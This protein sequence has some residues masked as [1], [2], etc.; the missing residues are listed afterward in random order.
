MMSRSPSLSDLGS[1]LMTKQGRTR[2]V[3]IVLAAIG[4][5]A[6]AGCGSSNDD[7]YYCDSAGCYQCDAYGC[8]SVAAPTHQACTG[9]ASCP[10]GS[11]CTASGCTTT[12]SDG[13]PCAKGEVCKAGL[14]AAPAVD[15]GVKKDCTT[16]SDCGDGKACVAGSCEACG[17]VAGP[18]PC[19]AAKAATDCAAGQACIAGSCTSASNTCKF[20]SECDSGKVCAGGQ[21]L[22]S[23]EATPCATGFTCDKAVCKPTA[24]GGSGCATDQQCGGDTPQCVAGACVKAC[25]GDPECG[26]GKFCDQGACVI[27]TRPHPNCTD[28]SQCAGSGA[29]R[30]CL[31]G[32]CKYTCTVSQGDAYCRTIDNRIGY[33][34]KDLVCRSAAEANA[35]CLQSSECSD[36]KV[37]IDNSCK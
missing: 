22:V 33:C 21:C 23:C 35:Q 12:C 3:V 27:D 6:W 11:V 31:G 1:L 26:G 7:R 30:R 20:S 17:G 9:A 25:A 19:T 14:C 16:K 36:A 2:A 32:F 15:P 34:A 24:V 8:S 10:P 5:V 13:V 29:P 18:C 4:A 37:C 28:D